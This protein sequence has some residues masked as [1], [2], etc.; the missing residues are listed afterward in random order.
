M[1]IPDADTMEFAWT[2]EQWREQAVES[3]WAPDEFEEWWAQ[4]NDQGARIADAESGRTQEHDELGRFSG[5]GQHLTRNPSDFDP[6]ISERS[7]KVAEDANY[8]ADHGP[9]LDQ[10]AHQDDRGVRLAERGTAAALG[11]SA[12]DWQGTYETAEEMQRAAD[13][14]LGYG[15]VQGFSSDHAYE[16]RELLNALV[17]GEPEGEAS[18]LHAEAWSGP[19]WEGVHREDYDTEDA[20]VRGLKDADGSLDARFFQAFKD[21][22]PIAF[23]MASF[24]QGGPR[25]DAFWEHNG[26][27]DKAGREDETAADYGNDILLKIEGPSK[28]LDLDGG[29][30]VLT[31][32]TF[33]V[34]SHERAPMQMGDPRSG[35]EVYT[36]RQLALPDLPK[37]SRTGASTKKP[38][39]IHLGG[40]SLP[41]PSPIS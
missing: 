28:G 33:E 1:T 16:A 39:F 26:R 12:S 29:Y 38:V 15:E 30:E 3:G 27:G 41:R 7:M 4:A 35:A 40:G 14:L 31:G 11:Q 23:S 36:L 21:D 24:I 17:Y 22:T 5:P 25:G 18:N 34:V 10:S 2:K 9:N 20:L 37:A 32:G 6:Q 19:D 8:K 13:A